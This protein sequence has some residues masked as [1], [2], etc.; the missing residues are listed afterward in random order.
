M[1]FDI[2]WLIYWFIDWIFLV[3][4]WLN[5]IQNSTNLHNTVRVSVWFDTT[6]IYLMIKR[7]IQYAFVV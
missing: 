7:S 4:W 3:V 1:K 6:A 5:M 2:F